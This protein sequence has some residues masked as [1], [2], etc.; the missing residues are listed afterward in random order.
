MKK[1]LISTLMLSALW[2]VNAQ[3]QQQVGLPEVVPQTPE[4]AALSKY[5]ETPVSHYTGVPNISIPITSVQ[6]REL[7]VPVNISY[8]AGGI[9]VDEIATPI[10]LGWNLN[11]GG[12]ITRALK[13]L[14]DERFFLT[15]TT[16]RVDDVLNNPNAIEYDNSIKAARE[17][18]I[19]LEPDQFSFS[20]LGRSGKFM[21]NQTRTAEHPYG[22]IVQLPESDLKITPTIES[23]NIVKWEVKTN[24]GTTYIFGI[25]NV[26]ADHGYELTEESTTYTYDVNIDN[27]LWPPSP[28][29]AAT[30]SYSAWKLKKVISTNNDIVTFDYESYYLNNCAFGGE[31]FNNSTVR[32]EIKN[33]KITSVSSRIKSSRLKQINAS[34]GKVVFNYT[35]R[36]DH[37]EE[38]RIADI[39]IKDG[40]GNDIRK[41][42]LD[43]SYFQSSTSDQSGLSAVVNCGSGIDPTMLDKRLRLDALTFI[44]LPGGET[45]PQ[46]RSKYSFE[47]NEE[48][49]LPHRKSF[50]QDF[51]G[52][53]NGAT[54]NTG[55]M[56][57]MTYSSHC[58]PSIPTQ[59]V[60]LQNTN[61]RSVSP[62]HTQANIL[63]K[64]VFPTGGYEQLHFENNQA[65]IPSNSVEGLD[66]LVTPD[67]LHSINLNLAT[68]AVT[69]SNEI[70]S[71]TGLPIYKY[72]KPFEV[73]TDV[74]Y[75]GKVSLDFD[76]NICFSLDEFSATQSTHCEV[77]LS[78]VPA[79][80]TTP[81]YQ[82]TFSYDS[83]R[84]LYA[85]FNVTPG[86][87]NLILDVISDG[88]VPG[89]ANGTVRLT[90]YEENESNLN[91]G[92]S[93]SSDNIL[94]YIG[95]L[96][97]KQIDTHD[98]DGSL[99]NTRTFE[100]DEEFSKPIGLP[101][102]TECLEVTYRIEVAPATGNF[103]PIVE[104]GADYPVQINSSPVYPLLTTNGSFIGYTKV[105][106]TNRSMSGHENAALLGFTGLKKT[107]YTFDFFSVED[108]PNYYKGIPVSYD[109][110]SGNVLSKTYK[111]GINISKEETTY[112][113]SGIFPVLYTKGVEASKHYF[114]T[115]PEPGQP[116][117]FIDR[118]LHRHIFNKPV[119]EQSG[120]YVLT[121]ETVTTEYENNAEQQT[122][123][124]YIY[125]TNILAP[126]KIT[127]TLAD[128]SQRI[129]HNEFSNTDQTIAELPQLE[130][131]AFIDAN[132]KELIKTWTVDENSDVL[133]TVVNDM[134]QF[135]NGPLQPEGVRSSK[136]TS[137]LET[138]ISYHAYTDYG[139]PREVAMTNGTHIT[140]LWGYGYNYPVAKIENATYAQV[141]AIV[142][143]GSL[144]TATGDGLLSALDQL[145]SVLPNA[146]VTTYDYIPMI[147]VSKVV[148]PRGRTSTYTYDA[149]GRLQ[150]IIDHEGHV[151]QHN[152][153]NYKQN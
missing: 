100:Y 39:L 59:N 46:N 83:G 140:Y 117:Y 136:G 1:L 101:V 137:A 124:A 131:Q 18:Q 15:T 118:N 90:W 138:R 5:Q 70:D 61:D 30:G 146:M 134:K 95:G 64:I 143:E 19:D 11:T 110:R 2:G 51:W 82:N 6:G 28:N 81:V 139:Q 60:T 27:W 129:T 84:R 69:S 123:A 96:R 86:N 88:Y 107:E 103:P 42:V 35:T 80:Q 7:S 33:H 135:S 128:G 92:G 17:D 75:N 141:N 56:P 98:F 52:F 142:N 116:F 151:I 130:A 24:D 148:D 25:E 45:D 76:A 149:M 145:R 21:F 111:N 54:H 152:E 9:R 79:G 147:G 41:V 144:Q 71:A 47:Y 55:M 20:F 29:Q 12:Q 94:Y 106:E 26:S 34:K 74:L 113:Q 4:T 97:V 91:P 36:L 48:A 85:D 40:Q 32:D 87:Y 133:N 13:G 31:V 122:T 126:T 132:R 67:D 66:L 115:S 68:D 89:S 57:K 93:Q 153:Y 125:G 105:T 78:V 120:G 3:D 49:K 23:G 150:Y 72:V 16:E 38:A 65:R 53:Y 119:Y 114:K 8:H 108:I 104:A 37:S 14:P 99:I 112:G 121:T 109:W 10:G 50:A 22:Q 63:T 127:T 44:G 43:H 73:D 102:Y 58:N 62:L 77:R